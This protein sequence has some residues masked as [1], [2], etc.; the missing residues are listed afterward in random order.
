MQNHETTEAELYRKALINF[1]SR[2]RALESEVKTETSLKYNAY[3]R[4]AEL[5]AELNLLKSN[6]V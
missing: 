6:T 4:I 3:K 5:T 1:E 2:V